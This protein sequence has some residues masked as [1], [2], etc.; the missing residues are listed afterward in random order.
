MPW[1]IQLY[2]I[3]L[4]KYA[5]S[6]Q[7]KKTLCSIYSRATLP[8]IFLHRFTHQLAGGMANQSA[9]NIFRPAALSYDLF[10]KG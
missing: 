9:A 8:C 2:T 6:V 5:I 4:L 10:D 3:Y 7:L 1:G